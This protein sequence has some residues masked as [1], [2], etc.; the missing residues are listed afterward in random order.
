MNLGGSALMGHMMAPLRP[1]PQCPVCHKHQPLNKTVPKRF[2]ATIIF[3][4]LLATDL[5]NFG[6]GL[7]TG[8]TF[9]ICRS[10]NE[11][12]SEA[13]KHAVLP[14]R[15]SKSPSLRATGMILSVPTHLE[16]YGAVPL[17]SAHGHPLVC[18][19]HFEPIALSLMPMCPRQI[20]AVSKLRK[21][22]YSM[23]SDSELEAAPPEPEWT[24]GQYV[25]VP[26]DMQP[27]VNRDAGIGRI[28]E[29]SVDNSTKQGIYTVKYIVDNRTYEG[30]PRSI[31]TLQPDPTHGF[32]A[33]PPVRQVAVAR[34]TA[35]SLEGLSSD[36]RLQIEEEYNR[37]ES[38]IRHEYQQ[39]LDL[40]DA[41]NRALR[42]RQKQASA[43]LKEERKVRTDLETVTEEK[44][45]LERARVSKLTTTLNQLIQ[46]RDQAVGVADMST[47]QVAECDERLRAESK[48]HNEKMK[49]KDAHLTLVKADYY[50]LEANTT[51][52][53]QETTAQ[54]E[55]SEAEAKE[56]RAA[57]DKYEVELRGLRAL[58]DDLRPDEEGRISI[59][60][61]VKILVPQGEQEHL[62]TKSV[63]ALGKY[64]GSVKD[65]GETRARKMAQ[66]AN[67][68]ID[69]ILL[70]V[71]AG[72]ADASGVLEAITKLRDAQNSALGMALLGSHRQETDTASLVAQAYIRSVKAGDKKTARSMLSILVSSNLKDREVRFLCSEEAKLEIG[73]KVLVRTPGRG[74]SWPGIIT[75]FQGDSVIVVH[76][77]EDDAEEPA[78]TDD[79]MDVERPS[80]PGSW[81]ASASSSA[82]SSSA[83]SSSATS[84]SSASYIIERKYVQSP[85]LVICT[86]F[87]IRSLPPAPPSSSST[88]IL[89]SPRTTEPLALVGTSSSAVST[90]WK[91]LS[92]QGSEDTCKNDLPRC[93][94]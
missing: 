17:L 23:C 11:A 81:S 80:S 72:A 51:R 71:K 92:S 94:S 82:P 64:A 68:L 57:A 45:A 89:S 74:K 9:R 10:C 44:Q 19:M 22:D 53:L 20:Q 78:H 30:L 63:G 36:L 2:K 31:L 55:A 93:T 7:Q 70:S 25:S 60:S 26:E 4:G 69:V 29:A 14:E 79:S 85:G 12:I 6:C 86:H 50:R 33:A 87:Q 52:I 76:S 39:R 1:S 66:I 42:K 41:E 77:P 61:A 54:A 21:H 8:N 58:M 28:V 75:G 40:R 37:R 15:G 49:E 38:A 56:A 27:G 13:H 48:A 3:A 24:V 16:D 88:T 18:A 62:L 73:Q 59:E 65:M 84:S 35:S 47:A 34:S 46:Q 43:A 91:L 67:K 5:Q 90:D 83:T 32:S